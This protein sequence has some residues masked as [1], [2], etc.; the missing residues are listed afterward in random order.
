M[1]IYGNRE[2]T[3]E[4]RKKEYDINFVRNDDGISRYNN[5]KNKMQNNGWQ[6]S[7]SYNC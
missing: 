7:R 3:F 1:K 6:C 2:E 4:K 5:W